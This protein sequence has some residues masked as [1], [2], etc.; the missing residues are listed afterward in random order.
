MRFSA[1]RANVLGVVGGVAGAQGE[2]RGGEAA[3]GDLADVLADLRGHEVWVVD[4]SGVPG[5]NLGQ[6]Q[7][8]E[9]R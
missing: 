6:R 2:G 1:P 9:W 5:E 4:D 7:E 3:L 8:A